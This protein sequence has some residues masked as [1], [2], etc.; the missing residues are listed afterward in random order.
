MSP[1]MTVVTKC[2][3]PQATAIE[4]FA[5]VLIGTRGCRVRFIRVPVTGSN[6]YHKL[7]ISDSEKGHKL[8]QTA[9]EDIDHE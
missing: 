3:A 6:S 4:I 8:K 7:F 9:N 2:R 1:Q 5:A